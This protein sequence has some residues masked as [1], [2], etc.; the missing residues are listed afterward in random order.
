MKK[1]GSILKLNNNDI[2]L[3]IGT[4]DKKHPEVIYFEGSF[5]IK[6]IINKET[7]KNDINTI[8]NTI[9]DILKEWL[10][11]SKDFKENYMLLLEVADEWIRHDKKSYLSFQIFLKPSESLLME[12]KNFNNLSQYILKN[13]ICDTSFIKDIFMDCGYYTSKT[14]K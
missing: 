10:K 5:Y 9:N 2:N 13:N 14:K 11:K 4:I 8:K 7:Y 3:K 6:P 1:I 12:E